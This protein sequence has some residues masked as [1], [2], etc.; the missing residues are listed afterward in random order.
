M[1]ELFLIM[2]PGSRGGKSRK[3]F[4]TI[5]CL[6][7]KRDVNYQ[8]KITTS[9]ND[10]YNFSVEANRNN[11]NKIL[12]VGGD[13]TINQVLNGFY[14]E[15]GKKI[16]DSKLGIVYTGT[17]PDFCKSYNIPTEITQAIQVVLDNKYIKIHIGKIILSDN[18]LDH[19]SEKSIKHNPDIKTKYFGCCANI[20]LGATLARY[21]NSGIRKYLGDYA[22]TF[23]SLMKTLINYKAN[24]FKVVIDGKKQEIKKVYSISIGIT[25]YIASGIKINNSLKY[26]DGRFYCMLV[27]NLNLFKIPGLIRKVYSGKSFRNNNYISLSY[28][29][30]IEV[31]Y[32]YS[33]PEVEFDGDPAGYLPCKI[34]MAVD[35]LELL[36]Q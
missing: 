27:K 17:S 25:K 7:K 33:N 35:P 11:Y 36:V 23:I 19:S 12:A 20:G 29:R 8:Y 18:K 10:A 4:D 1:N 28:C 22:G 3:I 34:E 2:N 21:A 32:N 13:G 15:S 6:L 9:L 16:S 26:G 5:F 14:D 31:F 30:K 24:D